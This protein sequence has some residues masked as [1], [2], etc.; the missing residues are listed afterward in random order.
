MFL[1]F[2]NQT[3]AIAHLAANGWKQ[4]EN[5]NW[6][7]RDGLCAANIGATFGERVAIQAWQIS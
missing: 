3:K 1:H 6:V 4:I 5:G 7:S 2:D